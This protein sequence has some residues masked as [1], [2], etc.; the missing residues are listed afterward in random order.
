MSDVSP[1]PPGIGTVDWSET[2]QAVR[3][4]V[5][6]LQQQ[7][8]TLSERVSALEERTRTTSRH[9]SQPPSSDPPS[10]PAPRNGKRS[11]R[12]QGGQRG[13]RGQGRPLLPP[14]AVDQVVDATPTACGQCGHLLLGVDPQ[15]ARHQVTEV[16]RVRPQ[17][18]E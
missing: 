18:T 2:P 5:L 4:L 6:A 11:V 3:I 10:A 1:P 16:P 12:K 9:A 7:V 8:V 13:H 15:P 14:E 17:V